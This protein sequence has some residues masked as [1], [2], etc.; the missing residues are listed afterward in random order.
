MPSTDNDFKGCSSP[1]CDRPMKAKGFCGAH[2][3]RLI[4]GRDTGTPIQDRTI[5]KYCSVETCHRKSTARGWC[6]THYTRWKYGKK[7]TLDDSEYGAEVMIG[8]D[9]IIWGTPS[10][11]RSNGYTLRAQRRVFEGGYRRRELE[12]RLVMEAHL[13]RL[14]QEGET[15]HHLNGDRGDNR[16]ENLELWSKRQP[17]GQRVKDKVTWVKEILALYEPDALR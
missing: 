13:G 8:V 10:T 14:L 15:V 5:V 7:L 16:I 1:D 3:Q 17:A 9:G 4:T 2:Y 11:D 12:H 6:D